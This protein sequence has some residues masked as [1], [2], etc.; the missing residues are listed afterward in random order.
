PR[1]ATCWCRPAPT[2]CCPVTWPRYAR[3]CAPRAACTA[4]SRGDRD[5]ALLLPAAGQ[6]R[7]PGRVPRAPPRGVAGDARRAPG[8]RVAQLLALPP[9]R[10]AADRVRRV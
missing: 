6:A 9:R 3:A 4:T 8:H 2:A 7:A 10:R 5:A 1:W